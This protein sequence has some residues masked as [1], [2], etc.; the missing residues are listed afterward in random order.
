MK[1]LPARLLMVDDEPDHVEIVR[2]A[3]ADSSPG[4]LLLE[5]GSLAEAD[6][7]VRS[8]HPELIIADWRLPDGEGIELL[9]PSRPAA[10]MPLV[11]L[12]GHGSDSIAVEA[13][14]RGA[15]DYV[16][17][18]ESTLADM[19]HIIERAFGQWL[20]LRERDRIA[21][22][23][24]ESEERYML[25]VRGSNDGI[26]DWSI[27]SGAF[28]VSDRWR[29]AFGFAETRFPA[30]ID[31]WMTLVHPQDREYLS[32]RLRDHIDGGS[33]QFE[34]ELRMRNAAGTYQW[35]HVRGA[36]VRDAQ[37]RAY[38]MAGSLTEISERKRIEQQLLFQAFHDSLTG[39]QN[40]ALFLQHIEQ[41]IQRLES[42][43]GPFAMLFLD[44]DRFKFINDSFGHAGGDMFLMTMA[45]RLKSHLRHSDAAARIGGDE[46]ALLLDSIDSTEH[47]MALASRLQRDLRDPFFIEGKTVYPSVSIGVAVSGPYCRRA[48]DLVRAADAAMYHAKAGGGPPITLSTE[49]MFA[50]SRWRLNAEH[51]L[52]QALAECEFEL[53]YQPVIELA[54][55]QIVAWEGLLRWNRPGRELIPAAEFITLA[56][57][58]HL[59]ADLD[60]FAIEAAARQQRQW[61]ALLGRPIPMSINVSA[62]FFSTA[63]FADRLEQVLASV[64]THEPWLNLEI[65]ER[66]LVERLSL[67]ESESGRL[68]RLR[69]GLWLDDFGSGYSSLRYLA[70][71][72]LNRIK[73]DGDFVARMLTSPKDAVVIRAVLSL[74]QSLA[75]P[76][77]AECIEQHAQ[78]E[79]LRALG[80][81]YGQGHY[82]S[83]PVPA[84]RVLESLDAM[85]LGAS[86]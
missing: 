27:A 9:H 85:R 37:G 42:G 45:G 38:R 2:R 49:A 64:S 59:T 63:G 16:V 57:E 48:E 70:G 32:H 51:D 50:T 47:A 13:L 81:H 55:D 33:A 56:E 20:A 62:G 68:E 40:R 65:T 36:A 26:W 69:I 3:F 15:L 83:A 60:R 79:H 21:Y 61:T 35:L 78:F 30:H 46:F 67:I 39:L 12:T 41:R 5:A 71:L 72:R 73:I 23:L 44:F 80:C 25:A 8:A 76:V 1:T 28:F 31:E 77:I 66:S 19:P 82:F 24:R 86:G 4:V 53:V 75:T 84:T 58:V 17:K 52:R 43:S 7:A 6:A 22:A 54:S 74:A 11:M 29:G 14:K 34:H 18:S 10:G